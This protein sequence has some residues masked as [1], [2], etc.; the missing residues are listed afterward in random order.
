M[1]KDQTAEIM[2]GDRLLGKVSYYQRED[3]FV[4]RPIEGAILRAEDLSHA[5]DKVMQLI[6]DLADEEAANV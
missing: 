3:T 6:D 1:I 4:F 5:L 2:H